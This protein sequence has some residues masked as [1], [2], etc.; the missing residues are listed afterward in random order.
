MTAKSYSVTRCPLCGGALDIPFV[1][2]ICGHG[3]HQSCLNGE[4]YEEVECSTCK[5]KINQFMSKIE[6]G[7][8]IAGE[9][10]KFYNDL[11]NE[12]NENKFDV[13]ASYLGK[14]IF[15]NKN[16][17]EPEQKPDINTLTSDY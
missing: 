6:E 10:E 16:D 2:F 15:I 7:R 11:N 5:T 14:G 3:Y 4:S 8:K 13:F 1:Y 9:P 17:E 12:N